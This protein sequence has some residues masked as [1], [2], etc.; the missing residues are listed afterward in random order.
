MSE[1][2]ERAQCNDTELCVRNWS[3]SLPLHPS[4]RPL[5]GLLAT[6]YLSSLE[7]WMLSI[8]LYVA[9]GPEQE[10]PHCLPAFSS[11]VP[12]SLYHHEI[13][14]LK[15]Q[16]TSPLTSTLDHSVPSE[17]SPESFKAHMMFRLLLQLPLYLFICLFSPSDCHV[18]FWKVRTVS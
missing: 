18:S 10:F 12:P 8:G 3:Y 9:V 16:L 2:T 1:Y 6:S 15:M 4:R 7:N 11:L 17:S 13:N 5:L 14:F